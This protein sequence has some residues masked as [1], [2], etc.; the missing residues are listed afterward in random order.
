MEVEFKHA[1]TYRY[2]II[3]AS[4][5]PKMVIYVLHGYGQLAKFFIRKFQHLSKDIMIVAPEGMHRFYLRESSGRVGASWMT[6]EARESDITDNIDWLNELDKQISDQYSISKRILIGFSQGGATAAR[7]ETL[8]AVSFDEMVLWACVFPPDLEL[9]SE[10]SRVKRP[11]FIIGSED[12][13]YTPDQQDALIAY[14]EKSG[15]NCIRYDGKHD[16]EN[17]TL[18]EIVRQMN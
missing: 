6:K 3:N 11:Y 12:E 9:N 8:G 18:N 2:E 5:S 1:K 10:A 15:Y 17:E 13:F 16:I 4:P 14:Y 7:W